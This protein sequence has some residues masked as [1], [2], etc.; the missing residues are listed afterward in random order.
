V[1]YGTT[2]EIVGPPT[3]VLP[4]ARVCVMANAVV[5]G[6]EYLRDSKGRRYGIIFSHTASEHRRTPCGRPHCDAPFFARHVGWHR[7]TD[8]TSIAVGETLTFESAPSGVAATATVKTS[9]SYTLPK[10]AVFRNDVTG[11]DYTT[12][13]DAHFSDAG[14]GSTASQPYYVTVVAPATGSEYDIDLASTMTLQSFPAE[15]DGPTDILAVSPASTYPERTHRRSS[16]ATSTWRS[17]VRRS[18]DGRWLV[19]VFSVPYGT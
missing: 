2:L 18:P 6:S 9:F 4:Q 17:S 12:T 14:F 10:G 16:A 8:L 7:G 19:E 13:E 11:F 15:L 1:T 3:G 5:A